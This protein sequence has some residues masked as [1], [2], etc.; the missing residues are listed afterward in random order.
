MVESIANSE[1]FPYS[2][3]EQEVLRF[4]ATP[5]ECASLYRKVALCEAL[6]LIL[7]IVLDW[8]HFLFLS[9]IHG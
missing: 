9:C 8:I 4:R 1:G 2:R 5:S 7:A 6:T 3:M